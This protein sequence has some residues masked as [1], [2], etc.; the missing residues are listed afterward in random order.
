MRAIPLSLIALLACLAAATPPACA[1]DLSGGNQGIVTIPSEPLGGTAYQKVKKLLPPH[2]GC[3]VMVLGEDSQGQPVEFKQGYGKRS[4]PKPGIEPG[5]P[6]TAA[7]NFRVGSFTKVA[8]AAGVLLLADQGKLSLDDPLTDWLPT[9]P[10]YAPLVTIRT[11]LNHTSGVPHYRDLLNEAR[12]PDASDVTVLRLLARRDP[13]NFPAGDRCEY[14]DTA[15]VLL[16]LV[17]QQASGQPFERFLQ[18]S[19]LRPAGMQRSEVF[20]EGLSRVADRAVGFHA[21]S[22]PQSIA[23]QRQLAQMIKMRD[24]LRQQGNN[25][26]LAAFEQRIALLEKQTAA[27]QLGAPGSMI[28]HE[29]DQSAYT[30]LRGDGSLYTSLDDLQAFFATLKERR[31]PL[32]E[33]G[34]KLWLE[35]QTEPI[36]G[37]PLLDHA[38]NRRFTCGWVVD[39]RLGEP[40]YSHRGSKRGFCQTI[41]WMPESER[42]VVVL[43]NCHPPGPSGPRGWDD[44]LIERLGETI[45]LAVLQPR[46]G[47]AGFQE[48]GSPTELSD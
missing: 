3:A 28:W 40:R 2:V 24:R 35:P 26:N 9:L 47:A 31:L 12:T 37:D 15:Y 10:A 20:V 33:E 39:E 32:S 34:Y 16:G 30:R 13:P 4:L 21:G 23:R 11:L 17:A 8:T 7:T 18:E 29:Q 42:L 46:D 1:Q 41:Q 43:L 14:S 6:V 36:G 22:G 19:V 48:L 38:K 5:Q 44:T 25:N 45:M 27:R